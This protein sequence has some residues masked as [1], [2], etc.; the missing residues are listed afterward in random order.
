MRDLENRVCLKFRKY[1]SGD[2]AWLYIHKGTSC[3]AN[4]GR[5]L[6]FGKTDVSLG[7][8]CLSK[9]LIQHELIHA[10]G[11]FHEQSRRDRDNYVKVLTW[12]I[13]PANLYNFDKTKKYEAETFGVPYDYNSI[14]HYTKTTWTRNG[15]DTMQAK[16][17]QD[18]RL[19]GTVLKKNGERWTEWSDWSR[20]IR[21]NYGCYRSKHRICLV[22]NLALCPGADEYGVQSNAQKCPSPSYCDVEPV[23]GFWG[24]WSSWAA[25]SKSCDK[26]TRRRSRQC[27]SPRPAN[28]GRNCKG[29]ATDTEKCMRR[30]CTANKYYTNFDNGFG[31]WSNVQGRNDPLNWQRGRGKMSQ[32]SGPQS[33]HTDGNGWYLYVST[34]SYTSHK[35]RAGL[36]SEYLSG[37]KCISLAYCM[38]GKNMGRL[39]FSLQ[40]SSGQWYNFPSTKKGHQGTGWHDIEFSLVNPAYTK[41]SYRF[42]IETTTGIG[43]YSDIAID[44]ILI[45][46]GA[47]GK[48]VEASKPNPGIA[49]VAAPTK[50]RTAFLGKNTE[51]AIRTLVRVTVLKILTVQPVAQTGQVRGN[52]RRIQYGCGRTAVNPAKSKEIAVKVTRIARFGQRMD[53]ATR[54][55]MLSTCG[56]P[57]VNPAKNGGKNNDVVAGQNEVIANKSKMDDR[58]LQI[59]ILIMGKCLLAPLLLIVLLAEASLCVEVDFGGRPA[60]PVEE[61]EVNPFDVISKQTKDDVLPATG[62]SVE[63]RTVYQGDIVLDEAENAALGLGRSTTQNIIVLTWPRKLWRTRTVPYIISGQSYDAVQKIE[64]AMRDL[65]KRVCLKFRKHQSGDKAWLNIYRGNSCWANIGR[66]LAFGKTDVSLG[67]SCL[68]QTL[69]QHELIHA[70]GFFHEQS[71]RDRDNYVNVLNWN[72]SP[73]N[74]YNFDKTKKYEAETFGVPY[75]YSSIMH[76]TKTTWTKNGQDTMQAKNDPDLRLGGT[77][78]AVKDGLSGPTGQDVYETIMA[79]IEANTEFAWLKTWLYVQEQMTMVSS[80]MHRNAPRQATVTLLRISNLFLVEP[81]DGFWGSWSSWSACSKSCDKGT[82]T[83]SRQ[84]NSPT[85]ANGGKKCKGAATDTEK[86][87]RRTCTANKYYTNFDNGFGVWSNVQGRNDPLNWQRGRG[88]TSQY[89]GPQSDHTDGNGWYLYVSTASYTSHKK[90]AG[91]ISEYLSGKKCISLAYCMRGKNMGRLDFSLQTSSGQWFNFPFTKKGHQGNGWHHAE[92]SLVNQAYTKT[93]YRFLIEATTGIG[94]YSDIAIDDILIEN[95]ACGA[96]QENVNAVKPKPG[97]AA[98][99]SEGKYVNIYDHSQPPRLKTTIHDFIRAYTNINTKQ[100]PNIER[101]QAVYLVVTTNK[102]RD[103]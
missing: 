85:P 37:K 63:S 55:A 8:S 7:P 41:T 29:A 101:H 27:N 31:V 97:V 54:K 2:K 72:I 89:S 62:R 28:G 22:E 33:D 25:C 73:A 87:M 36:I 17:D 67:P 98:V 82:R 47:C 9:T 46:N 93:S 26:G 44:D 12:N 1:K 49:P 102:T 34:A 88:K 38:R 84:C 68:S 3:W 18:L 4:I 24:S 75:D 96:G 80:Q 65:E 51:N 5:S 45:E 91:L 90:R 21:N 10:L 40:T 56:N 14:M 79:V 78:K 81:V 69:I 94:P 70:L 92:F 99:V 64:A 52:V 59:M 42:L 30:T 48:N 71:R 53:G 15:Q 23:D 60:R 77:T 13:S 76:Y 35:K 43:P 100:R 11:F 19:G 66:S 32:Y 58:M 86:C 95:G 6:A 61:E 57:A 39:D 50:T 20:C 83:R 16:N 74:L 103:R